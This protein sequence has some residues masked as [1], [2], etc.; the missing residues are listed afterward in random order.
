MKYLS[1]NGKIS[2]VKRNWVL[3][4]IMKN[5]LVKDAEVNDYRKL[6]GRICLR[7]EE[8]NEKFCLVQGEFSFWEN[9]KFSYEKL[10]GSVEEEK[11]EM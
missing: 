4:K 7:S 2:F 6:K 11:M 5:S 8:E 3:E 9:W 10:V 1:S